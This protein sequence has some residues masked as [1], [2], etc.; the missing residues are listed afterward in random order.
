[1]ASRVADRKMKRRIAGEL[2]TANRTTQPHRVDVRPASRR[3]Q[4]GEGGVSRV[5]DHGLAI[6]D[7]SMPHAKT[8]PPPAV[9]GGVARGEV[10]EEGEVR[11]VGGDAAVAFGGVRFGCDRLLHWAAE[12]IGKRLWKPGGRVGRLRD[13]L[14]PLEQGG[15]FVEPA[16]DETVADR[17]LDSPELLDHGAVGIGC[18]DAAHAPAAARERAVEGVVVGL[19][20]RVELVVVAA[21]AAHGG[22]E[23]RLRGGVDRVAD[24]LGAGRLGGGIVAMPPLSHPQRHR[25]DDRLVH[26]ARRVDPRRHEVAGELFDDQPIVGHIGIEG[27]HEVVAIPPGVLRGDVP[28]V[29]V[30]VGVVHHVHP[31]A[32]PV[33]A[34]VWAGQEMV[35]E[36]FVGV[37]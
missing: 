19:G 34:E 36:P 13:G 26:A 4:V 14:Q 28:L 33:F 5:G 21:G 27:P 23:K 9:G 32:G 37:R 1:M 31:M 10:G 22:G 12:E 11:G 25:A 30:R 2:R 6:R 35:D 15:A 16:G 29:A 24:V 3:Q 20:D 17:G 7:E 18:I 8:L